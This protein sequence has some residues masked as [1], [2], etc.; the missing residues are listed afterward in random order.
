MN[1]TIFFVALVVVFTGFCS[2]PVNA[3]EGVDK[4]SARKFYQTCIGKEIAECL[5]QTPHQL[6]RSE[7]LRAYAKIKA[8]KAI[9][10]TDHLEEL[11]Q[12]MTD[13]RVSLNRHSVEAYLNKRFA[14]ENGHLEEGLA[15]GNLEE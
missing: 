3:G 15:K 2:L 4:R 6:A 11:I 12:E 7:N 10:L 13:A 14:E 1:R 9:F 8:T 5:E